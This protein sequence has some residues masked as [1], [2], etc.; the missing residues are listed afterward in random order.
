MKQLIQWKNMLGSYRR[1]SD[2]FKENAI[3]RNPSK[4]LMNAMARAVLFIGVGTDPADF[5]GCGCAATHDISVWRDPMF[6]VIM[7]R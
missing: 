3:M 5:V 2:G 7:I 6:C 1:L 4:D